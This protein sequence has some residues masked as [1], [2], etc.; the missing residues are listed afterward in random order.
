MVGSK[1]SVSSATIGAVRL[2]VPLTASTSVAAMTVFVLT[3][4]RT[5]SLFVA[6]RI[7]TLKS[8]SSEGLFLPWLFLDTYF[9]ELNYKIGQHAVAKIL[10]LPNG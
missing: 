4:E 10:F 5:V 6:L 9:L 3:I 7:N 1:L 8:S 2:A